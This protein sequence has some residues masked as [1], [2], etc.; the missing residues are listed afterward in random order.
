MTPGTLWIITMSGICIVI[1]NSVTAVHLRNMESFITAVTQ[2][3]DL[4]P[5]LSPLAL[6]AN[7]RK[8]ADN[9]THDFVGSSDNRGDI[10]YENNSFFTEQ[11]NI[12]HNLSNFLDKVTHHFITDDHEERGVVLTPDG[13]TVALAPLLL[14]LE[15]GLRANETKNQPHG[16]YLLPLAKYLGMSF[17]QFENATPPERLGPD[18]CWDSVSA[19]LVFTLSGMPSLATDALV[20]GGMD[21]AILGKH[22]SVVNCSE[23]NLSTLLRSYYLETMEELDHDLSTHL[24]GRYRRQN[25]K[26]ITNSSLLQEKVADALHSHPQ[27]GDV[28]IESLIE[29]G[30]KEFMLHYMECPAIIPRCMWGAAPPLVPLEPLSPP[31]LFL[32]IHHTKIPSKP[33]RNLQ[34]CSKNMR[35][36]QHFHQKGRGWYDIGYSFVVGSDGYIYEGRGW[37]SVGAHTKGHNTVGYGVAFIGNYTAHLP[38]Q[39]DM[40]LVHHHLVKCGVSNGF[41]H[42]N[43]TILGHRQVVAGTGCP[44]ES[45][46][47]EITTWEHYKDTDSFKKH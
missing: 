6:V 44:G 21:G 16:F 32:Y 36:M 38:A 8:I 41:L 5:G 7:L 47:S 20:H 3:E 17:L 45:L 2:L 22:L 23:V 43:F 46:Y 31:L 28:G 42:E 15:Y 39:F 4:N 35:A 19:P 27:K 33:C 34:M 40:E 9:V 14:G 26:K 10:H 29:K 37:M 30:I 13:T 11:M 12:N 18:G 25:F 24:R 1:Q